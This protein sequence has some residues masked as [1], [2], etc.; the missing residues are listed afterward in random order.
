MGV[1]N[2]CSAFAPP[3]PRPSATGAG[4]LC[5]TVKTLKDWGWGSVSICCRWQFALATVTPASAIPTPAG[6]DVRPTTDRRLSTVY[7]SER[8]DA[9]Q[10]PTDQ[11]LANAVHLCP[12]PT[13]SSCRNQVALRSPV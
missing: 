5:P 11:G 13:N 6:R 10:A 1:L 8:L 3:P 7:N 9:P 12:T 2:L 4:P